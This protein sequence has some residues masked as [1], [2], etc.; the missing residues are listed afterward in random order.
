VHHLSKVDFIP[1]KEFESWREF[2]LKTGFDLDLHCFSGL[3]FTKHG[4]LFQ[5]EWNLEDRI[6]AS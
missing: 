5:Q 1:P 4:R 6:K 2:A 3:R